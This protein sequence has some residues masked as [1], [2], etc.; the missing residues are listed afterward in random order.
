MHECII[1]TPFVYI[2]YVFVLYGLGLHK[3]HGGFNWRIKVGIWHQNKCTTHI[4]Y[5]QC[6]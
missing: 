3:N 5:S 2:V 1:N 6:I 4:L